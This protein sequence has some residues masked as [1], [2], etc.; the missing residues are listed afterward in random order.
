MSRKLL[1]AVGAVVLALAACGPAAQEATPAPTSPPAQSTATPVATAPASATATPQAKPAATPTPAPTAKPAVAPTAAAVSGPKKGG[2][3][4]V[5]L[6]ADPPG[7]DMMKVTGGYNDLRKT[8]NAV[9]SMLFN[10]PTTEGSPACE[11]V[12]APDTAQSWK[13]VNDNLFE[14]KL[15]QGMRFQNKA[16]VNG[17]EV[18][19]DDVVFSLTRA[20]HQVPIRAIQPVA[21]HVKKIEAADRYTVRFETDQPLPALIPTGLFSQYG[22]VILAKES[23]GPTGTWDNP[24]IS[25]IGSGPFEFAGYRPG[26]KISLK[27][28]ADYWKPGLPYVDAVDFLIIPDQSTRVALLR[29][30]QADLWPDEMPSTVAEDI[31]ARNPKIELQGCPMTSGFGFLWMAQYG[32]NNPFLDVRVRRAVSMAIDRDAF[33]KTILHGE[34]VEAPYAPAVDPLFTRMSDYPPEL[35]RYLEYRPEDA[36]KLLAEAGY[37][38]GFKTS[39][40]VTAQYGSPHNEMVEAIAA[41]L[42][43][44]GIDVTIK[45]TEYVLWLERGQQAKWENMRFGKVNVDDPF[46]YLSRF[47]SK[48]SVGENKSK[49]RDSVMDQ[50]VDELGRTVDPDKQIDVAK[51]IQHRIA[52]QSW[53]VQVPQPLDYSAGN[54]WV[55]GFRRAGIAQKSAPWLERIWLDR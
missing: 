32:D 43:K 8:H 47:H 5:L 35:R 53:V 46:A 15:Q 36:K 27:R 20:F 2:L 55:K 18:T 39:I 26:V 12:I 11:S 30:G 48:A 49:V 1:A 14:V 25:Y 41:M 3:L 9:Y 50:L 4:K 38:N 22:A 40:E 21:A 42:P 16:P 33:I 13:W 7:W 54:P 52:D 17:R 6:R 37:P 19:A 23:A 29:S 28:F 44:I 51:K 34:G 31:R 24:D 10:T 45:W